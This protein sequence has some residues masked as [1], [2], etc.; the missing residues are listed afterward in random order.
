MCNVVPEMCIEGFNSCN[1]QAE[2]NLN[3]LELVPLL[4]KEIQNLRERVKE[5]ENWRVE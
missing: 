3:Y 2:K 1:N 5:L 4:L